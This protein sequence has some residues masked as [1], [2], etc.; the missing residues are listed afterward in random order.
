MAEGAALIA[1]A[2]AGGER[3]AA[4]AGAAAVGAGAAAAAAGLGFAELADSKNLR[5]SIAHAG[6]A[7][8]DVMRRAGSWLC[9][10]LS[11]VTC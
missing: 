3:T 1:H 6:W 4:V 10:G 11:L 2:T 8:L 9:A 7:R 5:M